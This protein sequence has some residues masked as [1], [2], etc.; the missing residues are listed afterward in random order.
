MGHRLVPFP[1]TRATA[2]MEHIITHVLHVGAS[3]RLAELPASTS[4]K[5]GRDKMSLRPAK[6]STPLPRQLSER[7]PQTLPAPASEPETSTT[8]SLSPIISTHDDL[9]ISSSDEF[10]GSDEESS[11]SESPLCDSEEVHG[12]PVYP[13]P[14]K[15][16]RPDGYV[17]D[18][19]E[20]PSP[21]AEGPPG[22]LAGLLIRR[23]WR[24]KPCQ[25]IGGKLLNNK[26]NF[27]SLPVFRAV[28]VYQTG[29]LQE[30][31]NRCFSCQ[32][33]QGISPDCVIGM[34]GEAC[35]NCLY[36][37]RRQEDCT[38]RDAPGNWRK[39]IAQ[40]ERIQRQ[41][42]KGIPQKKR[43]QVKVR[44]TKLK[45]GNILSSQPHSP[46]DRVQRAHHN[47][48]CQ[49]K[50]RYFQAQEKADDGFCCTGNQAS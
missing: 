22:T 3:R 4:T 11:D 2:T 38:A 45:A 14:E 29:S 16:L 49:P 30:E 8:G 42:R 25:I 44:R 36:Q 41:N 33:G 37:G 24:R 21:V 20:V 50:T 7:F 26:P 31:D 43:S 40:L 47:N 27:K 6:G 39:G 35:S 23:P 10:F 46:I 28:M 19:V 34:R 9:T 1:A 48:G 32:R 18:K 12:K 17:Y 5:L 13:G 15:G